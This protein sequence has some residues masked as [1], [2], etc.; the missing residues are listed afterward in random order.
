MGYDDVAQ[1]V[2]GEGGA[3]EDS[4]LAAWCGWR[5]CRLANGKCAGEG[6]EC[7]GKSALLVSLNGGE[8]SLRTLGGASGRH[9]DGARW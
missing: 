3:V 5:W 6:V 7:A 4:G 2:H 1:V 9:V 8:A